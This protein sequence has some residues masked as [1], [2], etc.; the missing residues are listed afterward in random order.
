MILEGA[1]FFILGIA[2]TVFIF[3]LLAPF[4][5]RRI[6]FF[7]SRR[8]RSQLPFSLEEVQ[9]DR[10]FLFAQHAVQI[11][12]QEERAK[13]LQKINDEQKLQLARDKEHLLKL[14]ELQNDNSNIEQ[15][16]IKYKTS[17]S[18]ESKKIEDVARAQSQNAKEVKD[19]YFDEKLVRVDIASYEQALKLMDKKITL[20]MQ[21]YMQLN[22]LLKEK[23]NSETEICL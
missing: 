15:K 17:L 3:I 21:K 13:L 7:I 5:W 10:K 18:N 19:L 22:E 4:I 12:R 20:L 23:A 9:A 6:L 16:L 8:L 2:I 14:Q 11:S 1:L